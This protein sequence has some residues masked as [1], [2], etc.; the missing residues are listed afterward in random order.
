MAIVSNKQVLLRNFVKTT[1]IVSDMELKLSPTEV[2]LTVPAGSGAILV[3]NLY[4]S[5][6]PYMR[7]RMRDFHGSYIHPFTPGSVHF[8]PFSFCLLFFFYISTSSE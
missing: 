5:C 8:F 4:L 2:P 6:D 3:K 7:G 1:P